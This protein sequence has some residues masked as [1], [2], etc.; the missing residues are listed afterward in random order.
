MRR[1]I[2]WLVGPPCGT[3]APN[4]GVATVDVDRAGH[5]HATRDD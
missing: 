4:A 2:S 5:D 1:K 3:R